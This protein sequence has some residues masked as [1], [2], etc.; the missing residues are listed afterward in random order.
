MTSRRQ[1]RGWLVLALGMWG[2]SC[3]S[4]DAKHS[5]EC[6]DD[7]DCDA[8]LVCSRGVCQPNRFAELAALH[9]GASGV[10]G[11]GNRHASGGEVAGGGS[12]QGGALDGHAGAGAG[13]PC[14][15]CI[16][17]ECQA[18]M[19]ACAT[20]AGCSDFARCTYACTDVECDTD[21][22]LEN[23]DAEA[24]YAEYLTC[25]ARECSEA[26]N[27]SAEDG[28]ASINDCMRCR[29]EDCT[30]ETIACHNDRS[31][32]EYYDCYARWLGCADE[33]C[34]WDCE[35]RFPAGAT[36]FSRL[37]TCLET[38]CAFC[39]SSEQGSGG[40]GGAGGDAECSPCLVANCGTEVDE[41]VASQACVDYDGCWIDC[42]DRACV[43][44]CDQA[45]PAGIPLHRAYEACM[46]D[47][48]SAVC[49]PGLEDSGG[50]GGAGGRGA[51]RPEL[52]G[53]GADTSQAGAGP[54]GAGPTGA[55]QA[56][57]GGRRECSEGE[58]SCSGLTS[59][60]TCLDGQWRSV[61][62]SDYEV[63]AQGHCLEVCDGSL[64]GS[65][66][67]S[68]CAFPMDEGSNT[69]LFL[70]TTDS[71][72]LGLS[73]HVRGFVS[74]GTNDAAIHA[75]SGTDWPWAW[76]MTPGLTGDTGW[77]EFVLTEFSPPLSAANL[78]YH[79][80]RVGF[81]SQ[82]VMQ[83]QGNAFNGAIFAEGT[84]TIGFDWATNRVYVP[85]PL[86][87]QFDPT[88]WNAL[89][90]TP[91]LAEGSVAD[92]VELSWFLLQIVE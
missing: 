27:W 28:G 14:G 41:C 36:L 7:R 57:A 25:A 30:T 2:V 37:R 75:T 48:C 13:D 54:T 44:D 6:R 1:L 51:G 72:R 91:I 15:A 8:P 69:G 39:F 50:A 74:D 60:Q 24:Q 84:T 67:P 40:A 80:R 90:F 9:G 89:S 76:A 10:A 59:V 78:Y 92:E 77:I 88:A 12:S 79:V 26:C 63:C 83:M 73:T 68:V 17:Q 65:A 87:D 29:N 58:T 38:S 35:G 45:V 23:P 61:S 5:G 71:E 21:C 18:N 62:C 43:A 47:R 22:S 56:G 85:S 81:T 32:H 52:G 34:E 20:E 55:G 86:V 19:E 49:D 31:C 3:T 70:W 64:S 11:A 66:L 33:G 53:A 46:N 4:D 16:D 42:G 82:G